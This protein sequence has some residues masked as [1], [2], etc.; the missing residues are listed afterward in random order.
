MEQVV[1]ANR[2]IPRGTQLTSADIHLE[3][4]DITQLHRGYLT[5]ISQAINK[6][7]ARNVR[8]G[9]PLSPSKINA[10]TVVKRGANV[11]ILSSVGSIEVRMKGIA[12][13]KGSIG[14]RI[15]VKNSRSKQQVNAVIISSTLVKVAP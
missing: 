12:L 4:R 8:Q 13:E 9:T 10:S 5:E 3:E 15:K 1:I 7:L 6:T 11:T 14:D 2:N